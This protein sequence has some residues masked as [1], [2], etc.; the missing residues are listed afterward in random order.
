M[1]VG[2]QHR[3][4]LHCPSSV[5]DSLRRSR[6]CPD[7]PA[8][9]TPRATPTRKKADTPEARSGRAR[10]RVGG[11]GSAVALYRGSWS[12][13]VGRSFRG[14]VA[15]ATAP[16]LLP[17][18][19]HSPDGSSHEDA[20][21]VCALIGEYAARNGLTEWAERALRACSPATAKAVMRRGGVAGKA[22]T[23]RAAHRI[24]AIIGR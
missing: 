9:P 3:G 4:L 16:P 19:P 22:R 6:V 10:R 21:V 20:G 5:S 14:R 18:P 13:S 24:A 2:G 7:P 8:T 12:V 1:L 23:P 15:G 11:G 17:P